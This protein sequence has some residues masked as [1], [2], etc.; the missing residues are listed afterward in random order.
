VAEHPETGTKFEVDLSEDFADY[1][2]K[3]AV[4]VGIYSVEYKFEKAK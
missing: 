4:P 2:E 1:D 3:A